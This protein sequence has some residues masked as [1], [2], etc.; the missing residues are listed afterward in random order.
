MD[1]GTEPTHAA[2]DYGFTEM[3][4]VKGHRRFILT[5]LLDRY[6]ESRDKEVWVAIVHRNDV[7]HYIMGI[8]DDLRE[9]LQTRFVANSILVGSNQFAQA[10]FMMVHHIS[11]PA[12][13]D[14]MFDPK[15]NTVLDVKKKEEDDP[16]VQG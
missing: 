3:P 10:N 15:T 12:I 1:E 9:A 8:Y 2:V 13:E 11:G 6:G 7:E 4:G 14:K 5:T 16:T